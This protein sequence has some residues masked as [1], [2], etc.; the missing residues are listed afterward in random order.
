MSE[1]AVGAASGLLMGLVFVTGS[2]FILFY[3]AKR[4]PPLIEDI[5]LRTSLINLFLSVSAISLALWGLIG[6]ILGVAFS[7][8]LRLAPGVGLGSPNMTYTITIIVLGVVPV[9]VVVLLRVRP[10]RAALAMVGGFI[11]I[12]GWLLPY[13]AS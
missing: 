4:R 6:L 5:L 9:P 7:G 10:Y 2:V 3:L 1:V 8:A 11:A 13:L 12:F